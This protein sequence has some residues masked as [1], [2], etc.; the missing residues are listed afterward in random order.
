MC[1]ANDSTKCFQR[2][3]HNIQ[4]LYFC[5]SIVS[6][7]GNF[8]K[9]HLFNCFCSQ[10]TKLKEQCQKQEETI[11]DQETELDSRR[12]E[13]QKLKDEEHALEQEYDNSLKEKEKI[14]LQLQDTQ[15]QISQIRAM[16]TQL[17]EIQRQMKDALELC[18]VAIEE[19]NAAIVSDYSLGIEP[20][21]RDFKNALMSPQEKPKDG[22]NFFY[23]WN[24]NN[25]NYLQRLLHMML[26]S[27]QIHQSS[28]IAL[29]V[30][31]MHLVMMIHLE[32]SGVIHLEQQLLLRLRSMIH[33]QLLIIIMV[34]LEKR[35]FLKD[36]Y[37]MFR[38]I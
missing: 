11:K 4:Y 37:I 31:P 1:N 7:C 5:L 9:Y 18:K 14:S 20:E 8:E 21:F 15:L 22:M 30:R 19:N 10:V 32:I 23:N 25:I 13:L 27:L 6:Y 34:A 36:I 3:V 29:T 33:L 2:R 26:S 17:E 38:I 16:F 12:V 24:T 28:R 35:F